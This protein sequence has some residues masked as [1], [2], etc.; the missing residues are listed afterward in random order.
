MGY[1]ESFIK[2]PSKD[3]LIQELQKYVNRD[4]QFDHA[5]VVGVSRV[6][7]G[8]LPFHKNELVMV[9]VGER[10]EQR[11]NEVLKRGLGIDNVKDITFIDNPYYYDLANGDL[12]TFLDENFERL[13]IEEFKNLL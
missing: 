6:I 12:G 4:K 3:I 8:I 10:S 5:N 11:N 2:F 9:V 7:K 13:S 1:Q